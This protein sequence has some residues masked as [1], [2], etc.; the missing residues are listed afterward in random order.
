MPLDE[1]LIILIAPNVGEQMGGEAIKALQIFREL[2]KVHPATIQ[3]T[4]ER[5]KAEL[6][7]RLRLPNVYYIAD[8]PVAL[9]LWH[10]RIFRWLLDP[11]FC[12]K[13]VRLAERLADEQ[14]TRFAR[15]IIHQTEPNSPVMPR[16]VSKKY[17][18]VFGPVNGNIYYPK[19]FRHSETLS[20]KLR[21]IF[22][23]PFQAFNRVFFRGVTRAN[24]V[25]CA[26]GARTRQSL[27]AAGCAEQIL[28]DSLDCG[29]GDE[30]LD[31]P[32]VQ[33]QGENFQFVH[34]GRLVFHKGTTLIIESLAKTKNRIC[35]DI[36]G[37]GPD[38]ERC[39]KPGPGSGTDRSR[40]FSGL[41]SK[42]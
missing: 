37:R 2:S 3:I 5:N 12:Q 39:R 41:V 32:R 30:I 8:T 36:I 19:I 6:S 25:L 27:L 20:G 1:K 16:F 40:Q 21:R 23:M 28:V 18:N 42:P 7:D 11:W 10:S 14:R 4:H 38:L 15:V 29:I 24:L 22:H 35:V 9:F 17:P 34:S 33:H 26:G 31:R 13:A